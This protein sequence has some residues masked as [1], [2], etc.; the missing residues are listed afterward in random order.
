M[1]NLEILTRI[2]C[3]FQASSELKVIFFKSIMLGIGV[4][5]RELTSSSRLIGCD[6]TFFPFNYL[7]GNG[8]L[9]GA[10]MNLIK[11]GDPNIVH[12]QEGCLLGNQKHC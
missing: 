12:M 1:G 9:I 4:T 6:P 8:G 7:K 5:E 10:N 2:L 3:C 11:H